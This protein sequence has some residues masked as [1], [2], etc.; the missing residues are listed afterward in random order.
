MQFLQV[1]GNGDCFG[2]GFAV[3][4]AQSGCLPC[5]VDGEEPR[6]AILA[7]EYVDRNRRQAQT[8]LQQEHPQA[9]RRRAFRVAPPRLGRPDD[10]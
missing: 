2:E 3:I 8:L 1:L 10:I 5:R 7:A 9:T 6:L 4:S